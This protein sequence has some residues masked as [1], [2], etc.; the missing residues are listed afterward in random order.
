M[1]MAHRPRWVTLS[2][3]PA[4]LGELVPLSTSAAHYL[5][6]LRAPRVSGHYHSAFGFSCCFSLSLEPL[7][8][9]LLGYQPATAHS[10]SGQVFLLNRVV[11]KPKRK[12]SHLSCFARSIRHSL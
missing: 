9:C 4:R 8:Q 12:P 1:R 7:M 11:Q 5:C 10:D 2:E 6:F 3:V